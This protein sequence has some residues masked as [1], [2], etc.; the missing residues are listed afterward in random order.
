MSQS[1]GC[2][3]KYK[4]LG[5]NEIS[6][7]MHLRYK[8]N[9]RGREGSDHPSP[10]SEPCMRFSCTRFS[11]RWF[12]HRDLHANMWASRL[13]KSPR[14]PKRHLATACERLSPFTLLP[15]LPTYV[16]SIPLLPPI[17]FNGD[18]GFCL[19]FSLLGTKKRS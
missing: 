2:S 16:P 13:V 15:G 1:V 7:F 12:P 17:P 9:D 4:T 14:S 10:P 5:R 19:L 11:D 18:A 6:G 8:M 3:I